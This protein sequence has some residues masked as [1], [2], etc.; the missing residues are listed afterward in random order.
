ME[1]ETQKF[2][3][4]I[5]APVEKNHRRFLPKI[6]LSPCLNLAVLQDQVSAT[7]TLLDNVGIFRNINQHRKWKI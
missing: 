6:I 7:L 1:I 5:S 2:P 3:Q 4:D